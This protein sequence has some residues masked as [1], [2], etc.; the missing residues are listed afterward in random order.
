MD[1]AIKR[2]NECIKTKSTELDLSYLDLTSLPDLPDNLT[3]LNCNGNKLTI[4]PTLPNSLTELNCDHNQL[5]NLPY[6]P[7]S[8]NDLHCVDNLLTTIPLKLWFNECTVDAGNS[9]LIFEN[10]AK[11]ILLR[12]MK[13][14]RWVKYFRQWVVIASLKTLLNLDTASIVASFV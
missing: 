10:T 5:T 9:Y 4:L 6:L 8:L 12:M 1:T 2:I 11:S 7:D 13:K 14:R 3:E